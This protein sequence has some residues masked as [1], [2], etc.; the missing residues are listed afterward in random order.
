MNKNEKVYLVILN[1]NGYKDTIECIESIF[2]STY[3]NYRIIIVDNNSSDNSVEKIRNWLDKFKNKNSYTIL[4]EDCDIKS[5]DSIVIIKSKENRGF[6]GGNNIGINY[7]LKQKDADFI[8]VLNND[9]TISEECIEN[10]VLYAKQ[11]SRYGLIGSTI[12]EYY[13]PEI[14]QYAAGA[15]FRLITCTSKPFMAGKKLEDIKF[16]D[17]SNIEIDYIGGCSMFFRTEVLED[18]GLLN[19]DYFLYFEEIDYSKRME[20]SE[21]KLGWCKDSLV[22]HKY[23]ASIGSENIVSKKSKTSEYYSNLSSAKFIRN[24]YPGLFNLIMVNRF[25]LKNLKYILSNRIYL[26]P[27]LFKSYKDILK[28]KKINNERY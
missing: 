15:K 11:N 6:A 3:K 10:L 17:E 13:N 26:I 27:I 9:V 14:I 5:N 16:L 22:Y 24:Y 7:I 28:D 21:Y 12:M 18:I 19:D 1:W 4:D 25:I 8:W 20:E 2:N 23:G